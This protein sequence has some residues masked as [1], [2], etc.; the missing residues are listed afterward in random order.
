MNEN[1]YANISPLREVNI[2]N[3]KNYLADRGWKEM[4]FRRDEVIKYQ[5]PYPLHG[6]KYLEILIPARR[7]L[8]DYTRIIEIAIYTVSA[9]EGRSFEEVLSQILIFGDLFKV[10]IKSPETK[11]GSIPIERG[12]LL[13]TSVRD[14]LIYSA[15]AQISPQKI[16]PRK[17][18]EAIEFVQNYDLIGQSQY[19]SFI[20]NFHCQ[21]K[22]PKQLDLALKFPTQ[23]GREVLVRIF[24]GLKNTEEAVSKESPDPIVEN[25]SRGLNANMC[26]TLVDII[27]IGSGRSLNFSANLEP[28]VQIPEDVRT[29]ITLHPPSE[30]YLAQAAEKLMGEIIREK[31]EISGFVFQLRKKPGEIGE[32]ERFIRLLTLTEDM[33]TLPVTIQLDERSYQLA[34]DAH[35]R[36]KKIQITGILEKIGRRWYLNEP[37]G[38]KIIEGIYD[39]G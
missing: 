33:G 9:F 35:K 31:R 36:M 8:I 5:S 19:G 4:P 15:C 18:G 29:D 27:K 3:F 23:F 12:I 34:I 21:L 39:Y 24:R 6:H 13:Y 22:R 16:Y 30:G 1:V 17:L 14:L 28:K 11:L 25:Y 37:E 26:E 38:L 7:D 2:Q 20:A 10:E 32:R